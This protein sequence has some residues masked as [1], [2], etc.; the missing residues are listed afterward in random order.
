MVPVLFR[1]LIGAWNPM[2]CPNWGF[3]HAYNRWL[4]ESEDAIVARITALHDAGLAVMFGEEKKLLIH[5]R[6]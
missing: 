2:L 3:R 5:E 6:A 4:G 1:M